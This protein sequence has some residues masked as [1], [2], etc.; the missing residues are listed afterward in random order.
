MRLTGRTRYR[1]NLF[2]K[3]IL[4][5]EETGE[6]MWQGSRRVALGSHW[7]DATATDLTESQAEGTRPGKA[8]AARF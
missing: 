2:G 4:Q 6:A 1:V 8:R 7:R 3:V 5:V